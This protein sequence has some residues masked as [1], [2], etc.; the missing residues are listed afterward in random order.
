ML[1]K[2]AIGVKKDLYILAEKGNILDIFALARWRKK[3][4]MAVD[5][6]R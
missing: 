5:T 1:E 4:L 3:D 2:T 6:K